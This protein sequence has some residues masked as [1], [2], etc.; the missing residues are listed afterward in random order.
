MLIDSNLVFLDS[1]EAKTADSLPVPL[2]SFWKPG[3]Q[4]PIP[5]CLKI[6]GGDLTGA[7]SLK[8][9]LQDGC[10]A[11]GPWEDVPGAGIAL[12]DAA[13]MK[14]G[15]SLGWR[16]L[17]PAAGNWLRLKVTVAG[18]VTG[19]GRLFAAVVR[20]DDLP[21]EDGMHIDGGVVRG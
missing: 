3:R 17:P 2:N 10:A 6:V 1:A 12:T 18:T 20:E 8:V 5:I 21:W 13:R 16:Y 19:E 4:E 15:R 14:A 9:Q 11:E 7:T